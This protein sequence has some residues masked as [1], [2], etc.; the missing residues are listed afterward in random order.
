MFWTLQHEDGVKLIRAS[1]CKIGALKKIFAGFKYKKS[2]LE[3]SYDAIIM[4]RNYRYA[5]PEQFMSLVQ[6]MHL[7]ELIY[8]RDAY[9][10]TVE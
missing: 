4:A 5:H 1:N 2:P 3:V 9:M 8:L 6:K 10:K 7:N